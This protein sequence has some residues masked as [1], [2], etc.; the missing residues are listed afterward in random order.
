MIYTKYIRLTFIECVAYNYH[1][2]KTL[3][4][5]LIVQC[6]NSTV[7]QIEHIPGTLDFSFCFKNRISTIFISIKSLISVGVVA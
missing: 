6:F 2:L 4:A 1:L 5:Y 3:F 7:S